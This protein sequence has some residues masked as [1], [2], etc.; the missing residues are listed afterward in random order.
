MQASRIQVRVRSNSYFI[1]LGLN[2]HNLA[3]LITG[4]DGTEQ[5]A[6]IYHPDKDSAC[7]LSD[8]PD[9]RYGHTQDGSLLCGGT[10]TNRSCRRW[11]ADTG[12][13]DLVTESL[14]ED[15]FY[16]I[17][18][19]PAG[20]SATYLIGGWRSFETSEVWDN[21]DNSRVVTSYS[22]KHMIW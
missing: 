14:T 2:Q 18:W 9:E 17:S 6:E 7:V 12:A 1:S 22:L 10:V 5:T 3:V 16:H 4:G 20:G 19:T 8:L 13:R 11:N 15:R 21:R